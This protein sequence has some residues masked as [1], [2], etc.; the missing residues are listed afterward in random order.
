MEHHAPLLTYIGICIIASALLALLSRAAKQPLIL[1][2]IIAGIILGKEMGFGLVVDGASIEL[3]SEI[4]LIFLLFIIGLEINVKDLVKMGGSML[5]IG[6]VQFFGT[7]F[8]VIGIFRLLNHAELNQNFNLIYLGVALSLSSTLIVVKLLQ[9]KFELLTASGQITLGIL[10]M[11]DIWAI[12]FMGL[13]P[14]LGNPDVVKIGVSFLSI[15]ALFAA[16]FIFSRYALTFLFRRIANQPELVLIVAMGWCFG[17]C[18]VASALSLSKEMGALVAGMTL[19]AFPFG[20]DIISKV[21][22]IRDFFVTLFFITL[23]LKVR[24]PTLD[25]LLLALVL[26]VLMLVLRQLTISVPAIFLKKGSRNGIIAGLNLSQISEFSLV[27]VAIGASLKQISPLLQDLILT[28]TILAA[29]ISTY[30]IQYNHSIGN[31]LLQW[32]GLMPKTQNQTEHENQ[33]SGHGG[34]GAGGRDIFVLGYFRIASEF[35]QYINER[36]PKL[37]KRIVIV[38][39]NPNH[40]EVLESQGYKW[41]YGDLAAVESLSHY[42]IDAADTIICSISNA[43]L[44][45]TDT[46]RILSSLKKMAP[47][48]KVILCADDDKTEKRLLAKGAYY[49]LVPG[50]ITGEMLFSRV[51]KD[52]TPKKRKK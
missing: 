51:H 30:L 43:F 37:A 29:V 21:I 18:S 48:S 4:G 16:T 26:V 33:H 5:L 40:R 7:F 22:G 41:V 42:G 38:D 46:D 13:Q 10:V 24:M 52:A 45:G 50:R 8:A 36:A 27:I 3:I 11:Q 6:V 25:V 12:L 23:G 28:A 34:H 49:V 1:G 35:V 32:T 39:Y 47:K 19:A 31:Q 15:A 44:K 14:N 17:I 2:Y 20:A 9:E